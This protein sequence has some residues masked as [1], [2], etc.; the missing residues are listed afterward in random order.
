MA[1]PLLAL[2]MFAAQGLISGQAKKAQARSAGQ[3]ANR[4]SKS[5]LES[6]ESVATAGAKEELRIRQRG[7][8]ALAAA[9]ATLAEAGIGPEDVGQD[10]LLAI[11][12]EI[13]LDALLTREGTE[14]QRKELVDGSKEQL[15]I[16]KDAKKA[17]SKAFF[18]L[19]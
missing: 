16:A 10:V 14:L 9:E 1:G 15:R 3:A 6:S 8:T 17:E 12:K 5:L 7:Q 13:E 18:G 19:F 4:S 11:Q 2:G